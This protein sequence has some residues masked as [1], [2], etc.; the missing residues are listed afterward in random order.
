MRKRIDHMDGWMNG[1]M[2][3]WVEE[4]L[5]N[6]KIIRMTVAPYVRRT[7][8]KIGR[9]NSDLQPSWSRITLLKINT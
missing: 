1:W 9:T 4:Y 2:N 8:R 3:G 6:T 7:L 5:K